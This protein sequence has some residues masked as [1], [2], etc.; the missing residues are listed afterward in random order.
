MSE[1]ASEK[2]RRETLEAMDRLGHNYDTPGVDPSNVPVFAKM[3]RLIGLIAIIALVSWGIFYG[4]YRSPF[5]E[6]VSGF[7]IYG[8]NDRQMYSFILGGVLLVV[9]FCFRFFIGVLIIG[10]VF[11]ILGI[12]RTIL[13]LI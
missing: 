10:L 13:K 4:S 11:R 12:F 7:G 6:L 3:I 2:E 8:R 5:E 1:K 9:G